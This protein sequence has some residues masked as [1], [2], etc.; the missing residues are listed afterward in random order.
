MFKSICNFP[1]EMLYL[2]QNK[3]IHLF[4]NFSEISFVL[5]SIFI[6]KMKINNK[7]SYFF[8]CHASYE[9]FFEIKFQE[10]TKIKIMPLYEARGF[11]HPTAIKELKKTLG[12][13]GTSLP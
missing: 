1:K 10:T 9:C 8:H 3:A 12:F 4:N 7:Y 5:P 11:F 6:F 13:V 2:H